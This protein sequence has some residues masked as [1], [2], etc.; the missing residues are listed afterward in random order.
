M[1]ALIWLASYPKSGNTW[2]RSFLLNLLRDGDE[3]AD[4]NTLDLVS[5][6]DSLRSWYESAAGGSLD[7][8][9]MPEI[10]RL[11]PAGHRKIS[12]LRPDA[13]PVKT[14]NF[15]G[16]WHDVPLHTASL[17][18][19]AVYIIRSPLDVVLSLA[20]HFGMT[21][22]DRAVAFMAEEGAG[23][24]LT[25]NYVPEFYRS[26]S[27]HVASWTGRNNP[28][29]HVVRYEDLLDD[30]ATYFKRLVIFLGIPANEEKIDRAIRFSSFGE[31][32]RQEIEKTFR[33]KSGKAKIFFREGRSEQ[34]RESLAQSQ[35][36]RL[37]AD[38]HEQMARFGY[39]PDDYEDA[40]PAPSV[41]ER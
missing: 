29:I 25:E 35:V 31:L 32:K 19:C 15:L 36:R 21:D 34:W 27:S 33:E 11:R 14:H 8:L 10:A 37:I 2:V 13:I 38:H 18:A 1:G 41:A 7:A 23:T 5:P 22:I 9:S 6:T 28:R 16:T 24:K 20:D 17:T 3:P 30:P 12:E 40:V 39:I 26:W 4:I